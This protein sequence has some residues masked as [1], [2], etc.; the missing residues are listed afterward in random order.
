[1]NEIENPRARVDGMRLRETEGAR[2]SHGVEHDGGVSSGGGRGS[3][4]GDGDCDGSD[5]GGG[6]FSE[7]HGNEPPLVRLVSDFRSGAD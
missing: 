5:G 4:G 2:A 6:Q 1:M 3:G 7:R